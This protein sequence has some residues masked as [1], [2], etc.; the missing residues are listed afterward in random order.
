MK[1]YLSEFM[2]GGIDGIVTTFSMI[3][4]ALGGNIDH[5]TILVLGIS[6]I[7]ADA[8]GMGV[9]RYLSSEIE[10]KQGILK[11]KTA[12]MSAIATFIAFILIGIIPLLPFFFF[13]KDT[14]Q[15]IAVILGSIAF[16]KIGSIKAYFLNEPIIKNGFITLFLGISSA[17]ISYYLGYILHKLLL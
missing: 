7:L 4:G 1:Q 2:Y 5:K 12:I 15:M 13:E 3:A 9:S 14:A 6:S 10:I 17:F 11:E 8:Y 16:F